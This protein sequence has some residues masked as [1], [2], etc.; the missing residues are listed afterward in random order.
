MERLARSMRSIVPDPF[1]IALALTALV[2]VAGAVQLTVSGDPD[3][4]KLIAG[5]TSGAPLPGASKATGGLWS[6][7]G[8]SAQM[9]LILI[10]GYAVASTRPV[11]AVIR[12]L[13]GLPRTTAQ[14]AVLIAAVAM[15]LSLLTWGLGL[16]AGALLARDVGREMQRLGRPVHYPLLAAA[17]YSGLAVWHGGLSGSAP[18]KVTQLAQLEEVLGADL[19]AR[20]GQLSLWDTVLSPRNLLT[21]GSACLV[22]LVVLALLAPRDSA[23]LVGPPPVAVE[24]EPSGRWYRSEGEGI[25]SFIEGGP[26]LS[27]LGVGLILWWAVPWA[28]DGGLASLSPN[29]L[30]LLFL[31][32]GLALAGSPIRFMRAAEQAAGACGG[33]LVQFP[34]YG[35]ILGVLV[36]SG[37]A[38]TISGWLPSSGALLSLGTFGSA[39]LLNLLVPSGG[40]QW[41]IQGPLVMDAATSA[42]IDPARIVLA[43][44]YG[45]QWTN[46]LQPFWALPLLGITGTKAG[47]ILGYTL[48]L[49]VAVG[50]VFALGVALG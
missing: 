3:L 29:S 17:G 11:R 37:L 5:W 14:A 16:I 40:G 9:C 31:G 20:V 15:G 6:L 18:L 25:A 46:L 28:L 24:K 32:L 1:A 34:L 30:N 44:S 48:V 2:F 7:L 35:G 50:F 36:A 27:L 49:A 22:I 45:D 47:D 21:T 19:A 23:P 43:L 10:T 41:A 39:G 12:G 26:W 8:F 33:I 38:T 13:A 42:G 4:S